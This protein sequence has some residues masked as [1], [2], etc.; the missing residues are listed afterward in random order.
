LALRSSP[1][2]HARRGQ[3]VVVGAK[4]KE[5]SATA[6]KTTSLPE[7]IKELVAGSLMLFLSAVNGFFARVFAFVATLLG[8][9]ASGA[10]E[11]TEIAKAVQ[12]LEAKVSTMGRK[13]GSKV[14]GADAVQ[15]MQSS[16]VAVLEKPAPAAPPA[17]EKAD[18]PKPAA[19]EKKEE[20]KAKLPEPTPEHK[21]EQK[22]EEKKEVK[23]EVKAKL[24]EPTP[25]PE[26]EQKEEEKKEVKEVM[27]VASAG[28]DLIAPIKNAPTSRISGSFLAVMLA[29]ITVPVALGALVVGRDFG[30]VLADFSLSSFVVVLLALTDMDN[31]SK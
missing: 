24:P 4:T 25:E 3:Y 14:V 30:G 29:I 21:P 19:A 12:A 1:L 2:S 10:K 28:P 7:T 6:E 9:R 17:E 5:R 16:S 15:P 8:K 20:V 27:A 13:K 31:K 22:K 11:D 23:E 26:P 18:A